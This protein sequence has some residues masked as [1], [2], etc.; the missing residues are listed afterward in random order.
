M[1]CFG[2]VQIGIEWHGDIAQEESPGLG[3]RDGGWGDVD[4]A[5]VAEWGEC[6]DGVFKVVGEVDIEP[7]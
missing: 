4:E 3:N 6:L 5:V 1:A 7:L 2:L